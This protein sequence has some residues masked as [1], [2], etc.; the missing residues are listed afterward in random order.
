MANDSVSDKAAQIAVA[1]C[2]AAAVL[3]FAMVAVTLERDVLTTASILE[4]R[5]FLVGL[6]TVFVAFMGLMAAFAVA[7]AMLRIIVSVCGGLLL[8]FNCLCGYFLIKVLIAGPQGLGYGAGFDGLTV[9]D[10][11]ILA[12]IGLALVFIVDLFFAVTLIPVMHAAGLDADFN[13]HP[14]R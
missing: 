14:R 11:R 2:F 1:V 4:G 3:G 8:F 7:Q 9:E 10:S 5:L 13:P 12:V 6:G